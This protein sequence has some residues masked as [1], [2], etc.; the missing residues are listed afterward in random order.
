LDRVPGLR[1]LMKATIKGGLELG[2]AVKALSAT[3]GRRWEQRGGGAASEPASAAAPVR[4]VPAPQPASTPATTPAAP[5]ATVRRKR[6][7]PVPVPAEPAAAPAARGA[8]APRL[9]QVDGIGPKVADVLVGDGITTV[10]RL[11]ETDEARLR[12]LLARAGRPYQSMDPS[13]WPAQARGL[14]AAGQTPHPPQ[15]V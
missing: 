6:A 12:A 10:E 5:R 7:R 14:L 2:D 3:A 11:A 4:D 15:S 8:K 13:T 1:A 9:T